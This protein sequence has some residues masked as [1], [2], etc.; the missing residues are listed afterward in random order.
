MSYF[1]INIVASLSI[2]L[3]AVLLVLRRRFIAPAFYPFAL[4][5][6]IGTINELISLEEIIYHHSNMLNS[7]I[8]VL[9][10]YLLLLWLFQQWNEWRYSSAFLLGCIG[11]AIWVIDNFF[12]HSIKTDNSFFRMAYSSIIVWLSMSQSTR[13]II[14]DTSHLYKNARFILCLTFI[15][16]YSFKTFFESY[17]LVNEGISDRF[18]YWL[19]LMLNVVNLF[20]NLCYSYVIVWIRKKTPFTLQ[21]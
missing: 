3:P 18:F 21:Y 4:L 15:I 13:I 12:W 8:Y 7:N 10:E 17:N 16:Y 19:W 11:I 2:M 14:N 5:V 1:A 6:W 20:T 9:I